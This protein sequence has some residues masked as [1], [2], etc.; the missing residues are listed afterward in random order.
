MFNPRPRVSLLPLNVG[1]SASSDH[2]V[3]LDDV[4]IDP[5]ALIDLADRHRQA[6]VPAAQNAFPGPELPLPDRVVAA[7]NEVLLLHARKTLGARRVRRSHGRLSLVTLAPHELSPM[8]R[9]CHR[10]R[11]GTLADEIALACV[12]YL[13]KDPALGGTA[14]YRPRRSSEV[15]NATMQEVNTMSHEALT[16]Q[17]GGPRGYLVRSNAWFEQ[18][19]VVPARFNRAIFYAGDLFHTSHVEHTEMLSADPRAGRLT[20]NG[21]FVCRRVSA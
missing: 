15:T 21:F 17:L 6:F 2:A 20:M 8:Q 9:L 16:A 11:L 7:L 19:A 4:L 13:F 14:F 3:V 5:D 10:D 18:T 12:V 1:Q